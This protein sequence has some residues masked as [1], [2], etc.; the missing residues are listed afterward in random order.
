MNSNDRKKLSQE[1][2]Q[3]SVIKVIIEKAKKKSEKHFELIR[4]EYSSAISSC[5]N[6]PKDLHHNVRKNG[7]DSVETDLKK[8][9]LELYVKEILEENEQNE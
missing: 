8:S 9:L 5:K 6:L 7:F 4:N 1:I 2:L 3:H